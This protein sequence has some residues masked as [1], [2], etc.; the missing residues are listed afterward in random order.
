MD[1]NVPKR[2]RAQTRSKLQK[3]LTAKGGE[4]YYSKKPHSRRS[5]Y[6]TAKAKPLTTKARS[7][8]IKKK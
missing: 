4:Y 7:I 5:D 3:G 1:M 8:H 6:A 2:T